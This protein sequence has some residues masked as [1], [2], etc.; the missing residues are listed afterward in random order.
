MGVPRDH[1]RERSLLGEIIFGRDHFWG[2]SFFG[3]LSLVK[4]D[5]TMPLLKK[6]VE[7]FVICF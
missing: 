5:F 1:F 7:I 3:L 6:Q 4:K 2:I